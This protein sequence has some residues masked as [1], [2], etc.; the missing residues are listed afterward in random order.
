[1][2]ERNNSEELIIVQNYLHISAAISVLSSILF[3]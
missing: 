3:A 2:S 1:M